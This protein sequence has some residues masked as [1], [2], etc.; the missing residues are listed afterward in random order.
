MAHYWSGA[1]EGTEVSPK[2]QAGKLIWP[3]QRPPQRLGDPASPLPLSDTPVLTHCPCAPVGGNRL[4]LHGAPEPVLC[5]QWPGH[6]RQA[7][8]SAFKSSSLQQRSPV[9]LFV[10]N[11]S[12]AAFIL[13][14][15]RSSLSNSLTGMTLGGH[16]HACHLWCLEHS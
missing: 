2:S 14:C 10:S 9:T 13:S 15:S 4:Q 1:V 8:S 6:F 16:P 3:L 11:C 12:R 5:L 7:A